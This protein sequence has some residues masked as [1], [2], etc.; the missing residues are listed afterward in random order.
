MDVSGADVAEVA[1][2]VLGEAVTVRDW[3]MEKIPYESGSPATGGLMRVCGTTA[4]GRAWSI[5]VK[6]VQHPRH[7]ER[8]HMLPAERREAFAAQFPWRQELQAWDEV[9][10]GRLP[11]GLR[12]PVLHR[13]TDLGDDRLLL[14]ME[15][16]DARAESAW[17]LGLFRRAATALGGLAALRGTAELIAANGLPSGWGLRKYAEGRLL[18]AAVP[19]LANDELWRHPLL[20]GSVDDRLR[21][22]MRTIADAFPSIL[23]RLDTLPQAIPHGDAS[24]QNLLAPRDDTGELIAID[25]AFQCPQAVGF[26]LGQLLV[27]LAHAGLLEVDALAEVHDVLVPAFVEGMRE[28]GGDATV[29]EVTFGYVGSLVVRAGLTALP[30]ELLG[31]SPSAELQLLFRQR[32]ALTRFLVDLGLELLG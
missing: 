5:F 17:D 16:V 29:D 2:L 4:D 3:R 20:A 31:A 12:V 6:Q 10:A 1:C 23:D 26:D 9:F 21:S 22:D 25:V 18:H 28:Y 8:L 32:A 19:V 24:P 15:D 11:A 30:Y 27:G 7:W 14:W 13:V